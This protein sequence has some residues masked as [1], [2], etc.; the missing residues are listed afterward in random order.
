MYIHIYIYIYTHILYHTIPY[1]T[2]C[3]FI[4][5]IAL[6]FAMSVNIDIRGEGVRP[7]LKTSRMSVY[8]SDTGMNAAYGQGLECGR[9]R[10]VI[11][12]MCIH[13]YIY[14]YTCIYAASLL[15]FSSEAAQPVSPSPKRG[16]ASYTYVYSYKYKYDYHLSLSLY[17]YIYMYVRGGLVRQPLYAGANP[18]FSSGRIGPVSI[19]SIFEFSI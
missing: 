17:I 15:K 13:I 18:A 11:I 8:L 1:Y 3:L 7:T 14:I 9:L 12:N 6:T 2:E 4:R 10:H 19:I 16:L 5:P